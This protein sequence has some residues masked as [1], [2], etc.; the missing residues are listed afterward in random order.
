MFT[1]LCHLTLWE[2]MQTMHEPWNRTLNTEL[3]R[4]YQAE[5]EL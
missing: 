5:N 1:T 3:A 4:T 2:S